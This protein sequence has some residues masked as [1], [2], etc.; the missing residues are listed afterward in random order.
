MITNYCVSHYY[1][2]MTSTYNIYT[3]SIS[4]SSII[5]LYNI[6]PYVHTSTHL[7]IYTSIHIYT[8]SISHTSIRLYTHIT[9]VRISIQS[10]STHLHI[11]TSTH[12]Y[13]HTST[14]IPHRQYTIPQNATQQTKSKTAFLLKLKSNRRN[15]YI[16]LHT[17]SI[18]TYI[19]THIHKSIH[20][21]HLSTH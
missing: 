14:H 19:Y 8:L 20:H 17:T 10:H 6:H 11:Y 13:I 2:H 21:T 12:L 4:L 7:H 15:Y 16:N 5:H 9:H 3:K 18:H 1:M